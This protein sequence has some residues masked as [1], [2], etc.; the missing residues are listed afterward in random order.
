MIGLPLVAGIIAWLLTGNLDKSY[1][2]KTTIYT[3]ILTGY[4]VDVSDSRNA[5][6]HM[7]NLMNVITTERTLKAVSIKLLTRC[8]IYGDAEKNTSY[9]TAEHFQQLQSIVPREVEALIDRDN[10][11]KTY[12]NLV[13]YE[14]PYANNFIYGI[15]NYS[16]PYFSVPVLSEKIKVA[17]LHNSDLIEIGYS[18]NDPGI[19]YNTLE[20]LNEEFV[21]QYR[22]LRYGETNNVIKFFREELARLHKQL[23]N[24]EDSLIEY[25]IE[26]RIINYG[27]Q[28]KQVTVMDANYQTLDNELLVNSSTSRALID[29]YENKLGD[30]AKYMRTNNEFMD[31]LQ[32]ISKLNTQISTMEI[33]PDSENDGR[34]NAQKTQLTRAEKDINKLAAKLSDEVAS[35]NN[36]SYETLVN[37]WLEQVV[38]RERTTAQIEARDIMREKLDKDF[39]YF[40]PIGATINRKE[41]N[42]SFVEGNYMSIMGALNQAILRQKNLEMT[43]ATLKVMNPPLF[44]LNSSATNRRMII[45]AVMLGAWVFTVFYFFLIELLDRTLRDKSRA[46]RLTK[47]EVLGVYPMDSLRY[48]RYNRAIDEMAIKQISTNILPYLNAHNGHV[49]NL[50]STETRDGKSH[51]AKNLEAYWTSMGLKVRRYTYDEDFQSETEDYVQAQGIK[52]ICPDLQDDEIAIVEYPV[53]KRNPMQANLLNEAAINLVVA[54]ANR[55]WKDTDNLIL[56]RLLD[57]KQEDTPI[58]LLLTQADRGALEEFTG[59]LPPYTKFKNLEYRLFQLGL[60]AIEYHK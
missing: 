32:E 11:E 22:D 51:I 48:R 50:L 21:K 26:H 57:M 56:K 5:S 39:L 24:A 15:L 28:T 31:K 10:E 30:L 8:L 36:V 46:K 33:T 1:D 34:L 55:T 37:S 19:A 49:V 23:T 2:V 27:E 59:Q 18:A 16:H 6:V 52:S 3:G 47:Q 42:I 40:S 44:P 43:A 35:T 38:I 4:N 41:R 53:L 14:R 54:R 12:N 7:S 13:A 17:Q 9:I 25:N 58:L 60:T 45:L 29:F 20:I